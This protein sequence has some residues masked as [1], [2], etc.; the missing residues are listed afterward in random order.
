M[1]CVQERPGRVRAHCIKV[2]EGEGDKQCT[3]LLPSELH[4]PTSLGAAGT[5]LTLFSLA[6]NFEASV[7][8]PTSNIAHNLV[9]DLVEGFHTHDGLDPHP[10]SEIHPGYHSHDGLA[11]HPVNKAHNE[12]EG[13]PMD[14]LGRRFGFAQGVDYEEYGLWEDG[15]GLEYGEERSGQ[16]SPFDDPFFKSFRPRKKKNPEQQQESSGRP[17]QPTRAPHKAPAREV[18]PT[19]QVFSQKKPKAR[20]AKVTV[21]K[22]AEQGGAGANSEM[23]REFTLMISKLLFQLS[24][25][26]A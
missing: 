1:T 21:E 22:Q 11:A 4:F 9:G 23:I 19:S 13:T 18:A 10:V 20:P 17:Q 6:S 15:D 16:D 12:E 14:T 24:Q 8:H 25:M 7:G 3:M 5:I 26:K 2:G